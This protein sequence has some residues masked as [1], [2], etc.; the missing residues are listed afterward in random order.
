MM[1]DPLIPH[2]SK[3]NTGIGHCTMQRLPPAV[4][5]AA[6][7][8]A[9]AGRAR[10]V[11][12][13]TSAR[14]YE[15]AACGDS[16]SRSLPSTSAAGVARSKAAAACGSVFDDPE[17]G[18]FRMVKWCV[19]RPAWPVVGNI[20]GWAW[21]ASVDA[22]ASLTM[23]AYYKYPPGFVCPADPVRPTAANL[24][25]AL[26]YF[27]DPSFGPADCTGR[28]PSFCT[29]LAWM[30]GCGT[31]GNHP[32]RLPAPPKKSTRKR[33]TSRKRTTTRKR[34]SAKKQTSARKRTSTR[35]AA[36]TS[37]R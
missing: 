10:A 11:A 35:R 29:Q 12:L 9:A 14:F 18:T 34:T 17:Y 5:V 28:L 36:A 33:T 1:L 7:L 31:V 6:A 19:E 4:L 15:G 30:Q 8:L 20:L 24:T 3:I 26:F 16:R 2:R 37:K 23:D 25:G 22:Y 27:Y 32:V 21:S 13:V